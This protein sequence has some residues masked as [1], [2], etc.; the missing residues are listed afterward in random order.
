MKGLRSDKP[1][2]LYVI[3]DTREGWVESV[4]K[5]I[6]AYFN[7]KAFPVVCALPYIAFFLVSCR[8]CLLS[9]PASVKCNTYCFF[10]FCLVFIS[11]LFI[12][13]SD[14]YFFRF[15]QEFDYSHIRPAGTLIKGFG[16]T[17]GGAEPLRQLHQ[18][19]H[20][21]LQPLQ[22][23]PVTVTAIVDLMNLIG[24]CVVSGNVRRTAEIAFG[25]PFSEE[26]INLKNYHMNPQRAEFGWTSNNS[27]FAPLG[28]DYT[29]IAKRIRDNGEPGIAWLENMQA[30]SR[31][32][33]AP[34]CFCHSAI[35]YYYY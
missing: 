8:S 21:V 24:K 15:L 32:D 27:V 13:I 17:S 6:D 35:Y 14:Y 34:V 5:L 1:T 12:T 2:E 33:A 25:D 10:V 26:Y 4:R 3:P 7:P 31:M 11:L 28:M 19:I 22:G 18:S 23:K 20:A 30:Y 16:G 29:N 9:F